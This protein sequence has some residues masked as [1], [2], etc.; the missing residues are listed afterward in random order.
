MSGWI[1]SFSCALLVPVRAEDESVEDEA[2][3]ETIP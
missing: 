3:A 2:E 1:S